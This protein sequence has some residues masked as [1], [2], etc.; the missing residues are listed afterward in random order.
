MSARTSCA[1]RPKPRNRDRLS[2]TVAGGAQHWAS[3]AESDDEP[4]PILGKRISRRLSRQSPEAFLC[5]V[6]APDVALG[7]AASDARR[8]RQ[9]DD[10]TSCPTGTNRDLISCHRNPR[11]DFGLHLVK[12]VAERHAARQI[13]NICRIIPLAFLDHD[14]ITHGSILEASLPEDALQCARLQRGFDKLSP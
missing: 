6:R 7:G 13:R 10:P 14:S 4:L 5:D 9:G 2:E 11:A 12:R 3:V 8:T 1:S